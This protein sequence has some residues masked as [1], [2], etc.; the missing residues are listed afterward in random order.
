MKNFLLLLFALTI[1]SFSSS[2]QFSFDIPGIKMPTKNPNAKPVVKQ[3]IPNVTKEIIND[4]VLVQGGTFTMGCTEEQEGECSDTEYPAHKVTLDNFYISKFEVT[5]EQ[6]YSIMD[7]NPSLYA[8]CAKCPVEFVSFDDAIKFINK[9]NELTGKKFRLPTE[10]EWEFAARGGNNSAGNKY[11]GGNDLN[12]FAWLDDNSGK[13]PNPVGKNKANEL[14]LID[15]SGNVLEWC[16]DWFDDMY[17]KSSPAKNPKGADNGSYRVIRG[18][19]WD[20]SAIDCRVSARRDAA[21]ETKN[22]VIGF[23]LA[24]D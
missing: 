18:G 11:S 7:T 17:Y 4:M 16:S 3:K 2:A 5:Q 15:M 21:P 1:I 14:G 19:S 24:M 8:N 6:Y 9:L 12:M 22:A 10:A 13:A 23:R 20:S